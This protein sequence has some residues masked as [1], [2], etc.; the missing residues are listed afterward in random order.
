MILDSD[1]VML[2]KYL[3]LN[4]VILI[5]LISSKKVFPFKKIYFVFL[6]EIFFVRN[7]ILS[8]F[9]KALATIKLKLA[10]IQGS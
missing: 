4:L 5:S 8:I 9:A 10:H 2:S 7:R 1:E 6:C 3:I